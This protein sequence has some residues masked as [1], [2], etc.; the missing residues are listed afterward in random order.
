MVPGLRREAV[1]EHWYFV[2]E[3]PR[4]ARGK[5]AREQVRIAVLKGNDA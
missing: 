1:P 3:I 4:N 5:I 2:S